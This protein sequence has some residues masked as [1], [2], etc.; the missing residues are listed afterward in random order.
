MSCL[1]AGICLSGRATANPHPVK[2]LVYEEIRYEE[3]CRGQCVRQTT[4]AGRGQL[5]RELDGQQP[6]ECGELDDGVQRH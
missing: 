2:R 1:R 5:D 4:A 3:K 6:E